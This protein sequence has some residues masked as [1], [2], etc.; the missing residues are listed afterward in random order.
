MARILKVKEMGENF[1]GRKSG[2]SHGKELGKH[3]VDL[4]SYK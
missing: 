2:L 1:S 3:I 4:G